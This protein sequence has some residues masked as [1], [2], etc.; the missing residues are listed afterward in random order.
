MAEMPEMQEQ[1]PACSERE[2]ECEMTLS[3]LAN[4]RFHPPSFGA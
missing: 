3:H 4:I 1:I 2:I